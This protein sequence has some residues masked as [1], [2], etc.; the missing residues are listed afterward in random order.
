MTIFN[1]KAPWLLLFGDVA[2]FTVSLWITLLFRYIERPTTEAFV[3]HLVPFSLLFVVWALVFFISGLYE[4]QSIIFR[5]RLFGTLVQGQVVNMLIATAFFYFIPWYGISPKTTLFLYLFISLCLIVVWR[6]YGF[7]LLVPKSREKAVLIGSGEE[8]HELYREAQK[9][10]HYT[11]DF[12]FLIDLSTTPKG[13]IV[14]AIRSSSATLVVADL[15]NDKVQAIL[16]HLYNLLFSHIRFIGMDR[17]YEDMFDRIPLSLIKHSWF[18]ENVSASPKFV[19]DILKRVMDVSLG[20][21]LGIFSLVAYPFVAFAIKMEDKGPVFIAQDRIGKN[22]APIK[23]VKFRSMSVTAQD[24]TGTS[25]EQSVTRVGSFIRKTRIDELPQ[26]WN[27]IVGDLSLIG[28]RPELPP[29]VALYE[30]EIPF[31]GVRHLIKPGLSG[32]AQLYHTTPPKFSASNEDT[33]MKL[34]YDLFYIKNRSFVLDLMIA[35]KTVREL[36][37]RKGR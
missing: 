15:H 5:S 36:V 16:P 26:L 14:D 2:A 4:K 30:Q 22:N 28:P 11:V 7:F 17:V 3:A 20:L 35:L 1:K 32:W 34:S 33:K 27:V 25:Q 10:S 6:T 24:T 8:M 29:F 9:S 21:L 13:D 23:I 12:V 37:S 19:Y 31:Y 18:L